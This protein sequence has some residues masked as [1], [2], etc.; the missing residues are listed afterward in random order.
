MVRGLVSGGVLGPLEL[1]LEA[2][3]TD[4]EAVHGLDGVL[5]THVV[6]V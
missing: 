1:H 4:L 6:V 3:H 5:C 2:L